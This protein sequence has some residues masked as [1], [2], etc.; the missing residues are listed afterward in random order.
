MRL[1]SSLLLTMSAAARPRPVK[2]VAFDLDGTL[3]NPSH[4]LSDGTLAKLRE[5]HGL[6]VPLAFATGRSA[7]AVYEH[8]AALKL[9]GGEL[10]TICYNGAMCFTFPQPCADAADAN[11]RKTE[12]FSQAIPA[13]DAR[14]VVDWA[15]ARGILAQFYVGDEIYVVP[16]TDAHADFVRRYHELTGAS[17]AAVE[18]YPALEPAKI[19]LMTDEPDE[20]LAAVRAA[21]ASGELPADLATCRGSPPFFV[22]IL[23]GDVCKGAGLAKLCALRGVDMED[24]I[25]F[26]D[27]END[28]EFIR[29]AGLGVA[30]LNGRDAV[31]AVAKRVTGCTNAEDGVAQTLGELQAEGVLPAPP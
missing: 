30:M 31:K 19:L 9:P 15:A 26:G 29:D 1:L 17:H 2:L 12:H 13:D 3:L 25:A 16:K 24:V 6:G 8:V 28:V 27:G 4:R 18:S 10:P 11:A 7:P 20:V 14:I 5:L 23:R 22:E 21:Q